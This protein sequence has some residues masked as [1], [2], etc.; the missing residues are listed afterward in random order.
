MKATLYS[1]VEI[2]IIPI[3]C[4]Y[5]ARTYMHRYTAENSTTSSKIPKYL[6][7]EE[8]FV[9]L[10]ISCAKYHYAT[11]VARGST[12]IFETFIRRRS[13]WRTAYTCSIRTRKYTHKEAHKSKTRTR[14]DTARRRTYNRETYD[15]M[16]SSGKLRT[17]FST[18]AYESCCRKCEGKREAGKM[19]ANERVSRKSSSRERLSR[20]VS[21]S[22]LRAAARFPRARHEN[23]SRTF[24][25]SAVRLFPD[26]CLRVCALHICMYILRLSAQFIRDKSGEESNAISRI[27]FSSGA[28]KI[29]VLVRVSPGR[30]AK[31]R[32][33]QFIKKLRLV[34]TIFI[35][36]CTKSEL[37]TIVK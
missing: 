20:Q 24:S 26:V 14:Y 1:S 37:K 27:E 13:C 4:V 35:R 7:G 12:S 17:V 22:T 18:V 16:C 5:Y 9:I 32:K 21:C 2:L 29:W 36:T 33:C 3:F 8:A 31:A 10:R 19:K 30:N 23:A 11:D 28:E 25:G 6:V 15:G 34:H